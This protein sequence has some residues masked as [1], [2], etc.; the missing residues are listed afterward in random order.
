MHLPE[1]SLRHGGRVLGCAAPCCGRLCKCVPSTML[2]VGRRLHHERRFTDTPHSLAM[3]I[4]RHASIRCRQVQGALPPVVPG[5]T[6]P[7][8]RHM[9]A[10]PS[11]GGAEL[12][13]A[14]FGPVRPLRPWLVVNPGKGTACASGFMAATVRPKQFP[15]RCAP[16]SRSK[17]FG[18]P[19]PPRCC[20]LIALLCGAARPT[21]TLGS[22]TRTR[23][24][25]SCN[26]ERK[27]HHG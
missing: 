3:K 14:P 8:S 25:R 22:P 21:L 15:R 10:L 16:S 18:P 24:A 9:P 11:C 27:L 13:I 5:Q 23:W 2:M 17:F 19:G 20:G 6:L 4:P 1:Q 7:A 26:L 12:A